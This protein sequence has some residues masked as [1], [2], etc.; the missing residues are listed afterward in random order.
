LKSSQKYEEVFVPEARSV[1]TS[2][3]LSAFFYNESGEKQ[4]LCGVIESQMVTG[5]N[6][7][8][9]L[10]KGKIHTV[11]LETGLKCTILV[12][13]KTQKVVSISATRNRRKYG[14]LARGDSANICIFPNRRKEWLSFLR[15][16]QTDNL[17]R[18]GS[19][20][21][22]ILPKQRL[23]YQLDDAKFFLT[24]REFATVLSLSK[25]VCEM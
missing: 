23:I 21:W 11:L 22:Q 12:S 16:A 5:P 8:L 3:P 14:K 25:L 2:S 4:K 7:D 17:F 24:Y 13:A 20:Y 18:A 10:K 6:I 19:Q 1:S 9:C 15:G